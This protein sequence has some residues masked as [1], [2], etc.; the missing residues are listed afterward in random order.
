MRSNLLK[1][2]S[3]TLVLY[4]CLGLAAVITIFPFIWMFFST[5]KTEAEILKVPLQLFP[6]QF[7]LDNYAYVWK[8]LGIF[9]RYMFNSAFVTLSVVVLNVFFDSLAAF[10]FAKLK[11]KGK[12]FLFA[13]F[14]AALLVPA[15]VMYI[16]LF[17]LMQAFHWTNTY[18]GLIIPGATSAF[19]IFLVWQYM[20]SIPDDFLEAARIEGASDFQVYWRVY[21]PLS[22]PALASLAIFQFIN[23]WNDFLWPLI[24]TDTTEMRTLTVGIALM[25]SNN[26]TSWSW[27]MTGAF[28][29]VVP[30]LIFY[31]FAQRYFI[32]GLTAGGIKG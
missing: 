14:M 16:E 4:L 26:V 8:S 31:I 27:L 18:M 15:Q 29:S 22:V 9:P 5:L 20:K 3:I 17:R 12:N 1:K 28:I 32:S 21:L 10:S 7:L 23:T 25:Q 13:F 19:G 24:V 30:V 11:F 2:N 6:T